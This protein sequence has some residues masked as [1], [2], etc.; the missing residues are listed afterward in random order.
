M[1]RH[2]P[3]VFDV[4]IVG[5]GPAGSSAAFPLAKKGLEVA[6]LEKSSLPR[7]KTCGGGVVRRAVNL[8][9]FDVREVIECEIYSVNINHLGADLQYHVRKEEPIISMTMRDNFDYFLTSAARDAGASIQSKCQVVDLEMSDE[10]VTLHTTNGQL[11]ARFV[12]AADG[13][14]SLVARKAGWQKHQLIVRAL[15]YE[16]TIPMKE[17]EKYKG[18]ARF[19]FGFIPFGYAWAFPKKEHLS[20]GIGSGK[21]LPRDLRN[22][23]EKYFG[24]I[25]VKDTKNI[26][27][28]GFFIPLRPRKG[29][30]MRDRI[31]LAGDAAGFVEPF[32]GEGITFAIMSGQL[33]AK[34]LLDGDLDKTRVRKH[35]GS[36]I[37]KR[38]LPEL[39]LGIFL[40]KLVHQYPKIGIH[41]FKLM[42]QKFVE[43]YVDLYHGPVNSNGLLPHLFRC[44]RR[45]DFGH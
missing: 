6:V 1:K 12:I 9:P 22:W 25:G 23:L 13:A 34:A 15:E 40:T 28:H 16:V 4:A 41:I 36:A 30:F 10:W 24:V 33:A 44:I 19:D 21:R 35:Y 5:S 37:E 20:I 42:G 14:T 11:R 39:R 3:N 17:L 2:S 32:S 26:D 8:L 31:L 27:R 43:H 7:Y 38:L 29:G 45:L 18:V